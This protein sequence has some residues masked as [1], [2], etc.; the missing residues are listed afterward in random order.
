[1]IAPIAE[2]WGVPMVFPFGA[3]LP[4][5]ALFNVARFM[6]PLLSTKPN[7]PPERKHDHSV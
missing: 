7:A 3:I 4:L 5:I 6:E 2:G 1:L